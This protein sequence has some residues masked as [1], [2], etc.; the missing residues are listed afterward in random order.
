LSQSAIAITPS[1]GAYFQEVVGETLRDNRVEASHA[2]EQYLVQLLADFVKPDEVVSSTLSKPVAILYKE[3]LDANGSERFNK[4]RGLGDGVLYGIGF[5]A[6]R[7]SD[8]D[9][10]YFVQIGRNA[11]GHAASM[12]KVGH[13]TPNDILGELA[14]KF[15]D[16]ARVLA[17][18]ANWVLAQGARGERGLVQ[19]YERWL[20]TG[21]RRL[22]AELCER[23]LMPSRSSGAC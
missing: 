6:V 16:F 11:Y 7:V 5:F 15:G 10:S 8:S 17:E 3:A 21:S 2:A 20:K 12:L 23:G 4:L 19:L 13:D 14:A 1:I 22:G 9:R 18:V